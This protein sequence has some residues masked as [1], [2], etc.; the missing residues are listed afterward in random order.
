VNND[1]ITA[2]YT[3]TATAAS[4]PGKYP[5]TPVLSDPQ[6][7]LLNYAVTPVNGILT[8]V[9][10][11][12]VS[13]S[14]TTLPF[15][16]QD[17][18]SA[19]A[20]LPLTVS[21]IGTAA[22][23]VTSV[24]LGGVNAQDFVVTNN[25]CTLVPVGGYCTI[26]LQFVP[27][28]LK[29]RT[30]VITVTD[31][32]GGYPGS[33]QNISLSGNGVLSYAVYATGT[34]CGVVTLSG[35][36]STDSFDASQGSYQTTRSNSQGNIAVNGNAALNGN[37]TV[38]GS[39]Y[40]PDPSIGKCNNGIPGVS[41]DGTA[42]ATGG[43]LP[44]DSPILFSTPAATVPGNSDL[45]VVSSAT[46]TPGKYRAI[47]VSGQVILVLMPGS[48]YLDSLALSGG[49]I[50]T[51]STGPVV[52]NIAGASSDKPLD[53]SGGSVASATGNPS[54]LILI[55]GGTK[56]LD[57]TGQSDSYGI[58]YAPNAAAYLK[59]T[60]DWFGALVVG[61]LTDSGASSIHYDRE[62]RQ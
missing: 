39:I 35:N 17:L 30:A 7:R 24:T 6:N 13:Y 55:Y 23:S 59:G 51:A 48:Y 57:L 56:E 21:N 44:L 22:L 18:F 49:S 33:Q 60:G 12:I 62:L 34:G 42:A 9:A 16:N 41:L 20:L 4:L 15:G 1:A 2:A 53:L 61:T 40:T 8:V 27:L 43:Y 50:V 37:V 31:N 58:L 45:H 28:A 52:L 36:A 5:I 32:A 10:A 26:S 46:L 19:T 11:P 38:N 25:N 54:N 29:S 47:T 3:T 14:P